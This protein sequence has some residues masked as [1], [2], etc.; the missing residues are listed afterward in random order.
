[1]KLET[2]ENELAPVI[3]WFHS[4]DWTPFDFQMEV[5]E[6]YLAG[7]SGLIHT[8]TGT[9]KTYAAWMGLILEWIRDN[10]SPI[11]VSKRS[12]AATL[13]ALWITPLRA[14][15]AD[16]E[17]ALRAPVETLGLGWTIETRTGDTS[18]TV[19]SRQR[20]RLPTALITT[21]ESL[22]LLLSRED[23]ADLF[24]HLRLVVVDEWHELMS[25]KRGV[26]TE[27]ALARL[28]RWRPELRTWGLSA[29]IGN[30]PTAL[31]ALLGLDFGTGEIREGVLISGTLPKETVIDSLLPDKIERFPWAGHLGLKLL[32]KVVQAIEEGGSTLVF[33]NTRSQTELWYQALLDAKPEWAGE[34][35]LHHGSLDSNVRRWVETALHEGK[36]KCVVSTS[37]LD[38]GVD[39]APVDRV[40]QIGSPKGVARLLQRAGRSGHRPGAISRVTCVPTNALELVE[41]AAARESAGRGEIEARLPLL[42]SLDVLSQ[43]LVTVGLGGGFIPEDMYREVRTAYA[44]RTLSR[45]DWEWAVDFVTHGGNALQSY[46]EYQR[47][48]EQG[49]ELVVTDKTVARMHRMS[50]GTITGDATLQVQYLK[51][52]KLGSIEESFVSRLKPGDSFT[53]GGKVLE[54]VR[55]RDMTVWVRRAKRKQGI[56]PRWY[57]GNLPISDQLSEGIREQLN[58]AR[59][60]NYDSAELL[61]IRP[62]LDLQTKW[63]RL[64]A[65]DELLIERVK[66]REGYHLFFF[67]FA[68]RLVHE[69]LAALFAYR[70]SRNQPITF[71][72]SSNDYGFELLSPDPVDNPIDL[73]LFTTQNLTEDILHSLNAAEMAKRQFREIARVAGLVFTRFPGGQ[74]TA[75]QLQISSSLLYEVLENYDPTNLLLSQAQREVLERQLESTRLR[76]TL[77][78]IGAGQLAIE[79]VRRPTPFAFPLLVERMRQTVTSETLE[80]RVR[81]ML[82]G[83]ERAADNS[84]K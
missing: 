66:T 71:T 25:T 68:G 12:Q 16:T 38:L 11:T 31:D 67:P 42:N 56:V 22:S 41:V 34:I 55:V 4:R 40:L 21:P 77:E 65:P 23:A 27:L 33:T 61:A 82:V 72:L 35:A 24:K 81:K 8:A 52:A 83:L 17:A 36:L 57:G 30:L 37:S 75:K 28:R 48:H 29:T 70:L 5:W 19:R 79:N 18:S 26:Q 60:G 13:L 76:M 64:P 1:M 49:G 20:T 80:D 32:P 62:I 59:L 74:K 39:F 78:R 63:S 50:I 84:T 14:L 54:F 3:D 2:R 73:D 10:P 51:G 6:A 15:A 58:K 9:G 7:K 43:H 46:P 44:Y 69:G 45:V 47:L 53:L